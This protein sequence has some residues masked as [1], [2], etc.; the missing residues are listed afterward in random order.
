MNRSTEMR[1]YFE[2]SFTTVVSVE[3]EVLMSNC[4][5]IMGLSEEICNPF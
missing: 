4:I 3:K 1:E 2:V 5:A